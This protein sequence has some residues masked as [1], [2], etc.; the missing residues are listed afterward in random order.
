MAELVQRMVEKLLK[1]TITHFDLRQLQYLQ[2]LAA[3]ITTRQLVSD[4][5]LSQIDI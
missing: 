5:R 1:A 4:S 3:W 2:R